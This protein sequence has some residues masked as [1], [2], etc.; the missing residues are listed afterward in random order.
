M[1]GINR[2]T[3]KCNYKV[4]QWNVYKIQYSNKHVFMNKLRA[5]N[6]VL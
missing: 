1:I 2:F 4:P 6:T 5:L 3:I